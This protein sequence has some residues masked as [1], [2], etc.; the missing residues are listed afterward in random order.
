MTEPYGPPVEAARERARKLLAA[1][2][3]TSSET[4]RDG[5]FRLLAEYRARLSELVNTAPLGRHAAPG[6]P[7][8][9]EKQAR[10]L[11]AVRAVYEAFAADPGVGKM[12]PHNEAMLTGACE[13]AGVTL[14]AYDRRIVHWLSGWEPDVCAVVADIITRAAAGSEAEDAPS[15]GW[16]LVM[17]QALTDAIRYCE[18]EAGN[19]PADQVALYR[20][21]ARELGIEVP[22]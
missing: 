7:L 16:R 22:E 3:E 5:L 13:A 21:L 9:T 19:W 4:P 6:P 11:P 18:R 20:S 14:G 1:S 10:T 2:V 8:E 12:A 17:A 15:P